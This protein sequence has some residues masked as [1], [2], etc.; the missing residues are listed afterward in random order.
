L[1][2]ECREISDGGVADYIPE[3]AKA[4][5]SWCGIALATTD[6]HVY[7]VGD[8]DRLFTIQS[9]S[10]PFVY[11]AMLDLLGV[12][13]VLDRVG[14]EPTG[15]AFNAIAVDEKSRR[16]FNPMVNAGAIVTTGLVP[17]DD[18]QDRAQR[19]LEILSS[20]AGR[21]LEIDDDVYESERST[22][23][24]NRAMAYL[25]RSFDMLDDPES[26]LDLYFR[27]CS[28]LV[29]CRDLALMAATLACSGRHPVTRERVLSDANVERVLSVMSSCGM[30]DFAGEWGYTVGLP[31]KSG[32]AGGIVAVLPGQL[33]VAVFSPPL[34]ERGNSV[35]GIHA[36][37]RISRE[38][39]LHTQRPRPRVGSAIRQTYR[40][41]TVRSLRVRP[42]DEHRVLDAEGQR[43][44]VFELQGD[45]MF[46]STEPVH[47]AVC[48]IA[49]DVDVVIFDFRRVHDIDRPAAE[50]LG[51]LAQDLVDRGRSVVLAHERAIGPMLTKTLATTHVEHFDDVSSALEW[52]EERLLA[53]LHESVEHG[54]LREQPLLAGLDEVALGAIEA[55]VE[56]TTHAAGERI[57]HEGDAADAIFFVLA[58]TVRVELP[59][60]DGTARQVAS[61]AR[62]MSFG[63]AALLEEGKRTADVVVEHDAEIAVLTIADLRDL[64]ADHPSITTDL[65]RNHAQM[66]AARLAS[67]NAQIRALD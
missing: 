27:Q 59:L 32:V 22:G 48:E 18:P 65:Y 29:T 44:A 8:T 4:D 47:R 63:E 17:G 13:A 50:I 24:R 61:F 36:C 14:V 16:P 52:C 33:G 67:A 42:P 56:V 57:V 20:F 51:A 62:G 45:L 7:E 35:R 55:R 64:M 1:L 10:K 34:D 46:T 28:A 23:D 31:S 30:Y 38:L 49:D 26:T 54:S 66:L 6:G 40:A 58:G 5:P 25:M 43:V 21:D 2:A 9:I 39:E 19:I 11:G 15:N 53:S 41:S 60:P 37:T 3:L 12:D